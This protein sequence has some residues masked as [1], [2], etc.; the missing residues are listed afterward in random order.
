MTKINELLL[1]QQKIIGQLESEKKNSEK[2]KNQVTNIDDCPL[3]LQKVSHDHK[4]KIIYEEEN[5][6][7]HKEEHLATTI[8]NTSEYKNKL[9][10]M[11]KLLQE[12][13]NAEKELSVMT[14]QIKNLNEKELDLLEKTTNLEKNQLEI[15][16]LSE[17]S[18][19]IIVQESEKFENNFAIIKKELENIVKE[20]RSLD[21]EKMKLATE[22]KN[23]EKFEAVLKFEINEKEKIK[24]NLEKIS[25]LENWIENKFT[26]IISIIEQQVLSKIYF[27]F[28]D[29]FKEIFSLL[30]SD[31]RL[32]PRINSQFTPLIEQN[33]YETEF[34]N[35]S[36]GEK[37]SLSLAYRLALN[38][39]INTIMPN[40]NTKGLL[41][42]DEPTDGFSSEQV[43]SMKDVFERIN[44]NQAIIVSHENK[45][46]SIADQVIRIVKKG[47]ESSIL[48]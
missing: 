32:S 47:H 24:L 10:E 48:G 28:N 37:A 22:I 40:I 35:L 30:I 26:K 7:K 6:I 25:N 20:E 3:C 33:G 13:N 4:S 21:L 2:I 43:D 14:L 1:E 27:T 41:L 39:S 23:S 29:Y 11:N 18:S 46:E 12:S 5:K 31:E 17:K 34:A 9:L 15:A 45:I 42:L 38:T 36:G 44:S 16:E 19:K 8:K